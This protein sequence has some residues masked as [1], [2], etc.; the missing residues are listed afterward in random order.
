MLT[1]ILASFALVTFAQPGDQQDY[2]PQ[3]VC[4]ARAEAWNGA[5]VSHNLSLTE[6]GAAV[7]ATSHWEPPRTGEIRPE[8][9]HLNTPRLSLT[10]DQ[11]SEK[12]LQSPSHVWGSVSAEGGDETILSDLR[13]LLFIDDDGPIFPLWGELLEHD[14]DRFG[15]LLRREVIG[16]FDGSGPADRLSHAQSARLVVVDADERV[17]AETRY[18]LSATAQRDQLF[19]EVRVK[20]TEAALVP[21]DCNPTIGALEYDAQHNSDP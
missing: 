14:F 20:M 1:V 8:S 4:S 9:S 19:A 6:T 2:V 13:L 7:H 3:W 5:S 12:P 10:Y 18:D 16:R 17:L 21:R 11:A 15:G